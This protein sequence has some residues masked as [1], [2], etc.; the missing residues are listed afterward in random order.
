V[1]PLPE[2]GGKDTILTMNNL[3]GAEIQ[4]APINPTAT[5]A[6]VTVVLFDKWYCENG[7]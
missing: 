6:E 7:L 5:A 4:L 3:L 1:V 2:E